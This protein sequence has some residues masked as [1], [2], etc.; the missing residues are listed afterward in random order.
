[1]PY[2]TI[3]D[4]KD[5]LNENEVAALL[6]D[7]ANSA[8]DGTRDE[9]VIVKAGRYIFG[10]IRSHYSNLNPA[11]LTPGV[12]VPEELT[13]LCAE[14]AAWYIRARQEFRDQDEWTRITTEIKEI[15]NG[16]AQISAPTTRLPD[17]TTRGRA[18]EYSDRTLQG[19]GEQPR[20]ADSSGLNEPYSDFDESPNDLNP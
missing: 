13:T 9:N 7:D 3:D 15:G 2:C 1:M 10:K 4:V 11:T 17:S 19:Y 14:L 20:G 18:K 8:I 6:D 16:E 5:L 12:D